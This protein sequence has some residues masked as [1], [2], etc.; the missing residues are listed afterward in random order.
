MKL[1]ILACTIISISFQITYNQSNYKGIALKN[2]NGYSTGDTIDIFGF[3]QNTSGKSSYLIGNGFNERYVSSA[4]L[5]LL[6]D[7]LDYWHVVWLEN[8]SSHI[9]S[10][11][12]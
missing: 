1:L 6:D 11:G 8:Q 10:S 5:E 4:K 3:K 2:I 9:N 12:W 7:N